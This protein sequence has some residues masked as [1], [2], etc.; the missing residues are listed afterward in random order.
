ML[1]FSC[2]PGTPG[3]RSVSS[4]S[5]C[6][7]REKPLGQVSTASHRFFATARPNIFPI[8]ESLV[9]GSLVPE[10]VEVDSGRIGPQAEAWL[11]GLLLGEPATTAARSTRFSQQGS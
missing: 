9:L 2:L 10:S 7:S 8:L 6:G 11:H 4:R 5:R 3:F 1:K